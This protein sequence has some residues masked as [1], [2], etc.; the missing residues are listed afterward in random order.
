[1]SSAHK[2]LPLL[3]KR[4]TTP[5]G[6]DGWLCTFYNHDSDGNISDAAYEH[7]IKSTIAK[8]SDFLPEGLTPTW[9]IRLRGLL[10]VDKTAPFEFG[11]SVAGKSGVIR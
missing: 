6:E 7:V 9:S 11:L 4:L 3:E 10:S 1:M 2:L 8:F 5:D